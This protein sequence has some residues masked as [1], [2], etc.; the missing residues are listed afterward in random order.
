MFPFRSNKNLCIHLHIFYLWLKILSAL[1]SDILVFR[2]S[3]IW[4]MLATRFL[5]WKT[6]LR[7]NTKPSQKMKQSQ[8]TDNNCPLKLQSKG[9][10]G[11]HF[12]L[13]NDSS[14]TCPN[15]E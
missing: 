1:N 12:K 11:K 2:I 7:S 9:S 6:K 4:K 3:I 5:N 13:F 8:V 14:N 15:F 10:Y